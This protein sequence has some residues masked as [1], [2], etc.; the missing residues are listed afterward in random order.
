MNQDFRDFLACLVEADARFLVVGAHALSVHGIPRATV[1]LDVLIDRTTENAHRVWQALA[2][3]GA[4]L[5]E[6]A[7]SEHDLLRPEVVIQFGLPPFRIDI[8]TSASGITFEEAWPDRVEADVD[9]V[10]AHFI[11]RA[12]FIKN[13]RAAGRQKDLGDLESLGEG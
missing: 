5:A 9:G 3:F 11:G 12:A 2:A 7:V 1:D 8:L 10:R 13:K 4:P 6:L